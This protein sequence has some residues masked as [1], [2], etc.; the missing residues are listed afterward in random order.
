MIGKDGY[1]TTQNIM[2]FDPWKYW[3]LGIVGGRGIGK[4]VAVQKLVLDDVLYNKDHDFVWVRTNPKAVSN[5]IKDFPDVIVKEKIYSKLQAKGSKFLVNDKIRGHFYA[6]SQAHN[7][8]GS[9]VN[10]KRVRY[11][12]FDEFNREMTEKK[13]YDLAD[14]FISIIQT[15][16]RPED[17]IRLHENG[18]DVPPLT[19]IFMGNDTQESSDLLERFN[20]IPREFGRYVLPMKMLVLEYVAD[21]DEWKRLREKS[22]LSVLR[23][24]GDKQLGQMTDEVRKSLTITTKRMGELTRPIHLYRMWLSYDMVVDVFSHKDG[25]WI[26][27]NYNEYV[28]SRLNKNYRDFTIH[29]KY[30]R[31]NRVFNK[32]ITDNLKTYLYTGIVTYD[33]PLTGSILINSIT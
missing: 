31:S 5:T 14:A 12:V 24:A 3:Y 27:R 22:P 2:G 28:I 21:D 6:L 4:T 15:V 16:G 8:K 19:I 29:P 11:I 10:W 17:R 25:I 18:E 30:I 13:M 26:S 7:I 1:Y 23:R 20:F 32:D 33:S 9:S